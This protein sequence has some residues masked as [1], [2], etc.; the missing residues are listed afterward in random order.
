MQVALVDINGSSLW[1]QQYDFDDLVA[2]QRDISQEL[3]QKL[4]LNLSDAEKSRLTSRDATNTEAYLYYLKGRY[5]WNKRTADDLRSAITEFEKAT[6]KDPD[7][8]LA[9]VGLADCYLLLEEYA[10]APTRESM[11][12]AEKAVELAL[13]KGPMLAE[14]HTSRARAYHNSWRWEEAEN[15]YRRAITLNPKYPTAHQWYSSFL[16][17]VGRLDQ[18]LA[19][20]K[21]AQE[22]DP[23]SPIITGNVGYIA[24]FKGD[25]TSAQNEFKKLIEMDS[26]FPMAYAGLGLVHLRQENREQAIIELQKAVDLS[27]RFGH[28]LSDL[29]FAY[30]V[31]GDRNNALAILKELEEKFRS[32][33][34]A[35]INLAA[36]YVGL[37][38]KDKAFSLLE[39]DLQR[40]SYELTRVASDP[41]FE[42]LRSD[43]RYA[44]LLKGMG[45]GR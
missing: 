9:Y 20:I 10:G 44:A 21:R 30:A 43:S 27:K 18:A 28:A 36:V 5:F 41:I 1:S 24:Y 34:T 3:A 39:T 8:A 31:S 45:L 29:G 22:L 35:A 26:S 17:D 42:P 33:Q 19:E 13:Q 40:G 15:A 16:T 7:F 12:E 23:Y 37:G 25:L 14:A 6:A 2:V 4:H 38:E 32:R 11:Q